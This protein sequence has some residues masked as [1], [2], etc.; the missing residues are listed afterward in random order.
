L[1]R[2]SRTGYKPVNESAPSENAYQRYS[3]DAEKRPL[4][5]REGSGLLMLVWHHTCQCKQ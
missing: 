4:R 3:P 2:R 1:C 5:R